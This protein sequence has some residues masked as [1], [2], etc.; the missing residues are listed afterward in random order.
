MSRESNPKIPSQN[1]LLVK[2]TQR[3]LQTRSVLYKYC[4]FHLP[5]CISKL[6]EII[7]LTPDDCEIELIYSSVP[8]SGKE[9]RQFQSKLWSFF[10]HP[11]KSPF[12]LLSIH[13]AIYLLNILQIWLN[14]YF[15]YENASGKCTLVSFHNIFHI[16]VLLVTLRRETIT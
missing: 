12:V 11:S 1:W 7:I 14:I 4:N 6:L 16:T 3:H 2:Q 8:L 5:S 9:W 13:W 15:W 10:I